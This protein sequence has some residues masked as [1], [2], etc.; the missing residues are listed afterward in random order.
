M[1]LT[2]TILKSCPLG[3]T[4]AILIILLQLPPTVVTIVNCLFA[5]LTFVPPTA[6][7][8]TSI[9]YLNDIFQGAGGTPTMATIAFVDAVF[10]VFWLFLWSPAQSFALDLAQAVVAITLGGGYSSRGSASDSAT[11]CIAI[12]SASHLLQRKAFRQWFFRYVWPTTTVSDSL[13]FRFMRFLPKMRDYHPSYRPGWLRSLLAV[14]ILTQGLVRMVR[15]WISR[16]ECIPP[17]SSVKKTDPE[18]A[19]GWQSSQANT[20][21]QSNWSNAVGAAIEGSPSP[22]PVG[23]AREG[24]ER[25]SSGKKRRKQGTYVRSQQPLWAAFASTKVTILR[26]YEQSQATAEAAGSRATG[27]DNLGSAPFDSEEG[28]VWITHVGPTSIHFRTGYFDMQRDEFCRSGKRGSDESVGV[29]KDKP[30]YVRINDADWTSIRLERASEAETDEDGREQ[31]SGEIFGLSPCCTYNCVFL[32]SESGE[33]LYTTKATT[34]P[35]PTT[36]QGNV[37][38]RDCAE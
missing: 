15:R 4:I 26:E 35:T 33:V 28:S 16:R 11:V 1:H 7:S 37:C 21:T 14:H 6:T 17:Q 18:A 22:A 19:G 12:I 23:N 24:K 36:E 20:T 31:W 8:I 9:P 30:F 29:R 5:L 32:R 2:A 13:S 38:P 25:I 34:T 10:L 3:D 27:I